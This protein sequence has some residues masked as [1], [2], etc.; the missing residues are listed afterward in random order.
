MMASIAMTHGPDRAAEP[1]HRFW[2]LAEG[3]AMFELG[4]FY[5]ARP[6]M[7]ALP[8]GDGHAVMTL[9][10]FMASNSSGV[11]GRLS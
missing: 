3:R 10:G 7:A 4:L 6:L 2:T 8:K 5:A 9:P 1:P 11:A